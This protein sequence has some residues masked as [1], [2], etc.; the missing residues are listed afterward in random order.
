M[1][2]DMRPLFFELRK[3]VVLW[4]ILA[5]SASQ[6]QRQLAELSGYSPVHFSKYEAR[7]THDVSR[8]SLSY[9]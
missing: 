2:A 7:R 3:I 1:V 9:Y 5:A 4:S 6:R 8:G